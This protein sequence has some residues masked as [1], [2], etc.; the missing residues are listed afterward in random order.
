VVV[1]LYILTSP[2]SFVGLMGLAMASDSCGGDSDESICS[3]GT[4]DFVI[5]L[6]LG[7]LIVGFI[8]ALVALAGARKMSPVVWWAALAAA[9]MSPLLGTTIALGIAGH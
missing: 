1:V 8:C 5:S 3:A 7:G 6:F 2:V 9:G 4:Q